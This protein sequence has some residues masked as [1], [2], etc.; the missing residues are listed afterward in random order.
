M[1]A[2]IP[3]VLA[4]TD[5]SDRAA[6]AVRR[7]YSI[8]DDGGT[9]HLLHVLEVTEPIVQ[10]N[11]LY[12][13]YV[14]GRAP[15]PEERFRQH[16]E[17]AERLLELVPDGADARAIRTEV[18][19]VDA[20]RAAEAIVEAADRLDASVV[21][22]GSHGR[23]GFLKA[24]LGSVAEHVVHHCRRPVLLVPVRTPAP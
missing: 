20:R 2:R 8:V 17:L 18:H 24:L 10:P 16:A 13:H 21:C 11:P 6:E 19:V 22:V 1:I 23:T 3:A 4:A 12:A 15:T 9:V 5:F 7:A 14:P